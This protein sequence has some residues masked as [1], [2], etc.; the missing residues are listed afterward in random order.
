MTPEAWLFHNS[1]QP[2]PDAP[3][4]LRNAKE[5]IGV[6]VLARNASNT[7]GRHLLLLQHGWPGGTAPWHE[8]I[9]AD[10]GSTDGTVEISREQAARIS[11][12]REKLVASIEPPADGDGLA[13][14]L[15]MTESDILLV[16]PADLIRLDLPSAATLL[17]RLVENPELALCL[18]AATAEGG[19]LSTLGTRPVL[20]ALL[21]ELALLSDP[22]TPLFALRTAL[23]RDLPL[24]GTSGYE[25]ALVA[26]CHLRLGLG[27]IGQ[28]KVPSLEWNETDPRLDAG[29]AFRSVVALLETL[30]EAKRITTDRELG[31]LLPR[32]REWS[33]ASPRVLTTLEVFR[34]KGKT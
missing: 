11:E 16:V 22:T 30:R 7:I 18:G 17:A 4:M 31:H 13:R 15:A 5:K 12:P 27:S 6:C 33:D 3:A 1:F 9:V 26:A 19:P 2:S 14:A 32:P 24:A 25:C 10:L 23:I 28:V 29:R 8:L 20:A 21:P 34:W